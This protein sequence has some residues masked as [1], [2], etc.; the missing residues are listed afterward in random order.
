MILIFMEQKNRVYIYSQR[1]NGDD[2]QIGQCKTVWEKA[3]RR[4]SENEDAAFQSYLKCYAK[5]ATG[6]P[7]FKAITSQAEGIV[8]RFR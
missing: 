7:F 4:P 1:L 3:S 8:S 2:R 6:K 5:E